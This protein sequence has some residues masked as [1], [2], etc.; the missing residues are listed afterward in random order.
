MTC[1]FQWRPLLDDALFRKYSFLEL[2]TFDGG[3]GF[4]NRALLG[5]VNSAEITD[6]VLRKKVLADFGELPHIDFHK[7]ER[8]RT[9]EKSCWINRCY[10]LVPLAQHAWNTNDTPLA[11]L[12]KNIMLH[13]LASCPPPD[14]IAAHWKRVEHRME[15]D[16]NRKS[17]EEYSLDETDVEYVWYDFQP[18]SRIIN[19]LHSLYFI[20]DIADFKPGEIDTIVEGLLVHGNVLY[21]QECGKDDQPGNHQ[22]LRLTALLHAASLEPASNASAKWR[23]L[24]FQRG[25]WHI[26][27]DFFANGT[28]A[29]NAP[30]YHAFE[31]WHGRDI[32]LAAQRFGYD[33]DTEC[34]ARIHLAGEALQA[35][36]RPDGLTLTINDAYPL[37]SDALLASLGM[38]ASATKR[39]TLLKQGGLAVFNGEI[40]YAALDVSNYTG[41]FSHYHGGKNALVLY[42][43]G[44][45][46]IDDPGCCNYDDP[47]FRACK[48]GEV[49]SSLLVDDCPDAHSFSVYGFDAYPEL[50]FGD[51]SQNVFSA[52]E[53]SNVPAWDGVIFQRTMECGDECIILKDNVSAPAKHKYTLL[54][55]LAPGIKATFFS[56]D[57]ILLAGKKHT[58]QMEISAPAAL[59]I[60]PTASYQS[61]PSKEI[62]QLQLAFEPSASLETRIIFTIL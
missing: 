29:E 62:L 17:F 22:S 26:K 12:V 43:G 61:D 46:F 52:K 37:A 19:F 59:S 18:A 25:A 47:R 20:K 38:E 55:I 60:L 33:M 9:I 35:Y 3:G 32:L 57:K 2:Y 41:M 21:E 7:C 56:S 51:W 30:S 53:S 36:R 11:T 1:N 13:F 54:F 28:L 24:A 16:Y 23:E 39:F 58:L 31:T 15:Y 5:S 49:H 34:K 27:N 40:F 50:E 44:E 4:I 48:Q 6:L 42:C 8:W 10:F 14:D 45:A